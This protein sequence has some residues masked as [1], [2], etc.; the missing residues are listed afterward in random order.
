M[1]G[2]CRTADDAFAAGWED[3]A[4]DKPLTQQEIEQLA[5]LHSPYLTPR[6]EAS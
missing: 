2:R 3:G 1:T 5:V 4:D 6:A